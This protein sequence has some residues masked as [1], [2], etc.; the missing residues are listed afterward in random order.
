ME[1][2]IFFYYGQQKELILK[3]P[4]AWSL[5]FNRLS[6]QSCEAHENIKCERKKK[7]HRGSISMQK[8]QKLRQ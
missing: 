6:N 3:C 1:E 2:K 5:L 4:N 8:E 7:F